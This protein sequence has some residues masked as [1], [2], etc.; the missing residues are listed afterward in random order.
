MPSSRIFS[1]PFSG[2]TPFVAAATAAL[3]TALAVPSAGAVAV[4]PAP[5]STPSPAAG[6]V[7]GQAALDQLGDSLPQVARDNGMSAATLRSTLLNDPTLT[8]DSSGELAY[9]E[10]AAPDDLL[11]AAQASADD[12]SG[13]AAA[14][15][16]QAFSL[17]SLPGADLTIYLDFDGNVTEGTS[18]N[19]GALIDSPPYSTDAD[20]AFS[21]TELDRIVA[22][23][24]I[25][26]EDFAPWGVNVTTIDPGAEALRR[27]SSTDTQYGVRVVVTDDTW[28]NC[29]CGGIAYIGSFMDSL[30]EPVWVYN[31]SL[32]GVAEAASHEVG[33]SLLLAHDGV[34]GGS[35]YYT[36]HGTGETSWA[37]IMGASYYNSTTQ[38]SL[39]E[40]PGANNTGAAGNYNRGADDVALL[41]F[42]PTGNDLRLRADDH[43][44]TSVDATA[45]TSG[46]ANSGIIG[47]REDT[48]AFSFTTSG[49]NVTLAANPL[50]AP[51]A[52]LDLS[53]TV[54][55]SSGTE[56]AVVDQPEAHAASFSG[57]L[58]A[59]TYTAVLDGV[60]AGDPTVSPPTGYTDY[61]SL[62]QYTF[63]ATFESTPNP[64]TTPPAAP[65]GLTATLT[66]GDVDLTWSANTEADLAG[67]ALKRASS[68]AGPFTTIDT[69][70]A[71]A[72]SATDT[73]PMSGLNV[74]VLTASDTS[75]NESAASSSASVTIT[76][77]PTSFATGDTAVSGIVSGSYTA[78]QAADGVS[79]SITEVS[80][81][82]K[83]SNRYD[84]LEHQWSIPATTGAQSLTIVATS[85]DAGD[86]DTG[87][88]VDV[89]TDGQS[90][91]PVTTFTGSIDANYPIGTPTGTVLVRVV[92]TDSS[93]GALSPDTVSV[94]LLRLDGGPVVEATNAVV[95]DFTVGQQGAGRGSTY[96]TVSVTITND[97]GQPVAGATVDIA[98]SGD[99]SDTVTLT[100][101]SSGSASYTTTT[102]LRK[103][104]F[105]ACITDVNA[106][107][108]TYL[109]GT[110]CRAG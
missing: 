34:E 66:S 40:Y 90:W 21:S 38:W 67:Y 52:N 49:G 93:A 54:V 72:T 43:G 87:F 26:A 11:D 10:H 94:D 7:G 56:V 88:R 92:D 71:S 102:A 48:D 95:S 57:S 1:R 42:P 16:E 41:S 82:G 33:H 45:V 61:A 53:L 97:L 50:T 70:G 25:V 28:A 12:G 64:D 99:F 3:V 58:A 62:G 108:L 13:T 51:T 75:G 19:S 81:G 37:P 104:S 100:T 89:S 6:Y 2:R 39:Q 105:S 76:S 36:G 5:P 103:P 30:D 24:E 85:T 59:G 96:G 63:T 78:T 32:R 77:T 22:S 60:G 101:N 4:A 69:L 14:T 20:P 84:T 79:Q 106:G 98:F 55:D 91:T 27:S 8:V 29:G 65:T 86:A 18:W 83:P 46:E 44:D 109:G 35:S 17:A 110:V 23:W 31:T 68:T 47:T 73:N 9:F 80:S 15:A 107:T 74:Y